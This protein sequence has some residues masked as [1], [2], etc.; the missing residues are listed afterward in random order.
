LF[1]YP[2]INLFTEYLAGK[3]RPKEEDAAEELST[4]NMA[5]KDIDFELTEFQNL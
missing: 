4:K 5:D 1:D 3:L 2:S